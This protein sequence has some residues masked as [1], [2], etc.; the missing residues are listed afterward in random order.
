MTLGLSLQ[1][2]STPH[3]SNRFSA[4]FV[5]SSVRRDEWQSSVWDAYT[6]FHAPL[7][8]SRGWFPFLR[9]HPSNTYYLPGA[10]I[11][12]SSHSKNSHGL[13]S[14]DRI[15]QPSWCFTYWITFGLNKFFFKCLCPVLQQSKSHSDNQ[16]QSSTLW[17]KSAWKEERGE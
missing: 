4:R 7:N 6:L 17:L 13:R 15:A 16:R 14:W 12:P 10:T 5:T 9:K 8:A 3:H 2:I 11:K 1:C